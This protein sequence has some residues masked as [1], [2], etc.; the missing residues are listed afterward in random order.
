MSSL[1][2][3]QHMQTLVQTQ[4]MDQLE[5][6]VHELREKVTTLRAE[7]ERLTNLVSFMTVTK[8]HPEV[9]QRSH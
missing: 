7:V 4:R 2:F 1:K 9:Q 8:D 6:E 3:S 5:Q